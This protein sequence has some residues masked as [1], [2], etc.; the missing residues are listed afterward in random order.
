MEEFI[1]VIVKQMFIVHEHDG[2]V[3]FPLSKCFG[4]GPER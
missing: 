2:T 1:E 3:R 4:V